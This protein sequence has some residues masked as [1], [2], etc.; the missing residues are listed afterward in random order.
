MEAKQ[1]AKQQDLSTLI[2][3]SKV[4]QGPN[5]LIHD[6]KWNPHLF[7]IRFSKPSNNMLK[8][9][10]YEVLPVLPEDAKL[11]NS[12]RQ[13]K[14]KAEKLDFIR[15][16]CIPAVVIVIALILSTDKTNRSAFNVIF[17]VFLMLVPAW[18]Y[19]PLTR[20]SSELWNS[21][22]DW[23][24]PAFA[25]INSTYWR[26][27]TWY[28]NNVDALLYFPE[29]EMLKMKQFLGARG[30]ASARYICNDKVSWYHPSAEWRQVQQACSSMKSDVLDTG[31]PVHII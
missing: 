13:L 8:G 9:P 15:Y 20:M 14:Y 25:E 19:R 21:R 3:M 12:R 1:E 28:S 27:T 2:D 16:V 22:I 30:H 10:D 5:N 7:F 6:N 26:L 4:E 23:A 17:M 31:V 29:T 11:A 24:S 18:A